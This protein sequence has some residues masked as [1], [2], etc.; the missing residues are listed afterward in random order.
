MTGVAP[1]SEAPAA[2]AQE[3]PVPRLGESRWPPA[4]ALIAFLALNI[5]LRI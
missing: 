1:R 5:A 3:T 4:L 2:S